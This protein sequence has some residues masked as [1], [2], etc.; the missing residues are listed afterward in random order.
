VQ[1]DENVSTYKRVAILFVLLCLAVPS[2]LAQAAKKTGNLHGQVT[3]PSGAVVVG[4]TVTATTSDGKIQKAVSDKRGSY[5]FPALPEGNVTV[6]VSASGFSAYQMPFVIIRAGQSQQLDIALSIEVEKQQVTV[7]SQSPG[8]TLDVNPENNASAIILKGKDLEALSDDPDEL[9]QD[10]L[11]LAGPSVGP[12][13][14]QIYI[15]GF[16]SGTLPP[17]SAIREI[18]INQNPFSAEYD[19]PGYGR[20]EVFTKPGSEKWH[21][22]GMFNENNSVFNSRNPYVHGEVPSYHSELYR[23]NASGSLS[24]RLSVFFDAEHRDIHDLNAVADTVFTPQGEDVPS[25]RSRTNL[26]TRLDFQITPNNTLT[27]R[28]QFVSNN[29]QALGI[30]GLVL[31]SQGYNSDETEHTLQISDSQILGAH[32]INETRFQFIRNDTSQDAAQGGASINVLG[33]F[34]GGGN[35]VGQSSDSINRYELQ[36]YTSWAAGKHFV[37]FGGRLRISQDD[38]T[39]NANANGTITYG[40]FLGDNSVVPP[41][42]AI[43]PLQAYLNGTPSQLS[44][45]NVVQPRASLAFADVGLYAEDDWKL[46]PN[47][48]LSYGLR[49]E[50]QSSIRDKADFAPR[51]GLSWGLG[52]TKSTPKTVLRFGY[53]IFYDRFTEDLILQTEHLNGIDE[54]QTIYKLSQ[55]IPGTC[56]TGSVAPGSSQPAPIDFSQCNLSSVSS[57]ASP[58]IY[59]INPNLHAPYTMQSAVSLERQLGSVGTVSLTY[60]YSRGLHQFILKNVNAPLPNQGDSTRPLLDTYGNGNVYQY[61]SDAIF[62]QNQ[63]IANVNFRISRRIS[64]IGYYVLGYANSDTNGASSSPSNQYNL[65]QDYGR[66]SFDIRQR[67]FLA[68]SASLAH[69]IRISP[70]VIMSSGDPFNITTGQD[71]GD[72]FFN[73]RPYF[74]TNPNDLAQNVVTTPYG[75]FDL[76]QGAGERLIPINYGRGAA[77]VTVNMRLS[78]TFGF[79]KETRNPEAAP[80]SG[81][82]G[83]RGH[84]GGGYGSPHGFHSVF[85]PSNTTRRYNLTLTVTARNLFNTWNPGLPVGNLSSSKFGETTAL[86]GGA[87]SSGTSNR[88]VNFQAIFS[89]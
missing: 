22:E 56:P 21:G 84:G 82:H 34:T 24:K 63:L 77:N 73:Q 72:T 4:A 33:E 68:G 19:R 38:S 23:G 44:V 51:L 45:T 55:A 49:F 70:F 53:G 47:L 41:I 27:A 32:V 80:E 37:K 88:R 16:S 60:L 29:Q 20:V 58:T 7:Q 65:T 35:T 89:F 5:T 10:L 83:H 25:P 43:S 61:N 85:A 64:L 52:S 79:G 40:G 17:K 76:V 69:N 18:R 11:A 12:N 15:D 74:A 42:A 26:S 36:N 39:S 2:A 54:L 75:K 13:G 8:T 30:G 81:G 78:K 62:K 59:Q 71:N 87:F 9:E 50:S 6:G 86:A 66:A 31:P 46:R 3:D 14:G 28:Y 67:V 48:T 57:S 1:E